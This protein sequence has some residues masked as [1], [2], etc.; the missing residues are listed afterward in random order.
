MNILCIYK[1]NCSTLIMYVFYDDQYDENN[2][3]N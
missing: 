1:F 3:A 2:G